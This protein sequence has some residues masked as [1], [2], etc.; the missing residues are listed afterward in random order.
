[1]APGGR[2]LLL[3]LVAAGGL[4]CY[5]NP[6]ELRGGSC[7][8]PGSTC[9]LDDECCQ[10][11]S[12]VNDGAFCIQ[13]TGLCHATC[14]INDDCVSDCCVPVTGQALGACMAAS[15]CGLRGVG[16]PCTSPSQCA[17]GS[18]QG[19]CEETCSAS[20]NLCRSTSSSLQNS[21]G[22]YNWC[23]ATSSGTSCFPGCSTTDDCAVYGAAYTC[24]MA[25]DVTGFTAKA[26]SL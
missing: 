10:S 12:G 25:T 23:F 9:T 17:S 20:D 5:P 7:Q 14:A 8:S 19:W 2:V 13:Q 4:A 22:F 21:E 24:K 1:V 26:C 11:G 3:A 16:D 6:D 18:C 15:F